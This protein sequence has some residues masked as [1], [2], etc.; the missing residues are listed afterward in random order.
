MWDILNTIDAKRAT[1]DT[2]IQGGATGADAL[3]KEW[4]KENKKNMEEY[5][6][7]WYT[8]G[9]GAGHV[10]N[11]LMLKEGKPDLVIAFP[12]GKGT[13]NMVRQARL[14]GVEVMETRNA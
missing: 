6:A 5:K 12:G 3:A 4:A 2:I 13:E 7:Q 14:K 11:A 8:Y 9:K 10:R 1:I